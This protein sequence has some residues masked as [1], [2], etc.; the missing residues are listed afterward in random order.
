MRTETQNRSRG[1]W[2][3]TIDH[4]M[5]RDSGAHQSRLGKMDMVQRRPTPLTC[6][7]QKTSTAVRA[8]QKNPT[9]LNTRFRSSLSWCSGERR[10]HSSA[11]E[12]SASQPSCAAGIALWV[13]PD[14]ESDQVEK[15]SAINQLGA[16]FRFRWEITL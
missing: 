13:S 14:L 7:S 4:G 9:T 10:V 15:T 2:D 5:M 1:A 11:G 12:R 16:L 8:R 3:L 6:F